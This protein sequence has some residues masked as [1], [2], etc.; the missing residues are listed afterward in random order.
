MAADMW[1]EEN[2]QKTMNGQNNKCCSPNEN[3]RKLIQEIRCGQSR[4][5]GHVMGR[6]K[7]EYLVTTDK[8]HGKK[9]RGKTAKYLEDLPACIIETR[10]Q[11]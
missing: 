2:A 11:T 7:F 10:T 1:F 3:N 5:F 4:F 8:L 9:A 6:N